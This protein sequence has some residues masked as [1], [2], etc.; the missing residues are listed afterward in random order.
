MQIGAEELIWATANQMACNA[1]TVSTGVRALLCGLASRLD[2]TAVQ[3]CATI[4]DVETLTALYAPDP[5]LTDLD[6]YAGYVGDTRRVITVALVDVLNPTGGMNVL[7]FRQFLVQPLQNQTGIN[8][9]DANGRFTA[10]YL[11]SPVPLQQGRFG[12]CGV[13]TGPGKVVLHR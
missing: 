5:D 2:N 12:S 11:G 1:N 4:P 6:D 8:P 13:S 10:S 9:S 7:G 3:G